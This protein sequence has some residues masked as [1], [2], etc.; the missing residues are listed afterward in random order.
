[1]SGVAVDSMPQ[2][3]L[4]ESVMFS[5]FFVLLALEELSLGGLFHGSVPINTFGSTRMIVVIDVWVI[6]SD[7]FELPVPIPSLAPQLSV[8]YSSVH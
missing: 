3:I 6:P 1:M 2:T 8:S 4:R 7:V 5:L